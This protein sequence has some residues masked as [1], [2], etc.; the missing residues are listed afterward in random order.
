[1]EKKGIQNRISFGG[2][3]DFIGK[4]CLKFLKKDEIIRN[5]VSIVPINGRSSVGKVSYTP[6]FE[7]RM[8]INNANLS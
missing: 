3:V 2:G 6:G 4:K 7:N 8:T 5:T 1:M